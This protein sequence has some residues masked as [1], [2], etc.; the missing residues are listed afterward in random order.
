MN[1]DVRHKHANVERLKSDKFVYGIILA[2]QPFTMWLIPVMHEMNSVL[3]EAANSLSTLEAARAGEQGRGFAV[4]ADEVRTL[5]Q[6]TQESTHE[7]QSMIEALQHGTT[8]AV[9]RMVSGQEQG[10]ITG[11]QIEKTG[12]VLKAIADA[13]GTV[14]TMNNQIAESFEE[15]TKVAEHINQNVLSITHS[16]KEVVS[17]TDTLDDA[18]NELNNL[19]NEL[20]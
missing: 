15:Q 10:N 1:Q 7:I 19:A 12:E 11:E 18:A 6:R 4:V 17:K 14:T 16:S 20:P 2:H 5:A 13:I 3:T 8:Q 9:S